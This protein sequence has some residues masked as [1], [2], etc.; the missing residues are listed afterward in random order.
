M[1]YDSISE[2]PQSEE[3]TMLS[4]GKELSKRSNFTYI[5]FDLNDNEPKLKY[6][7]SMRWK[8]AKLKYIFFLLKF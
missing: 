7:S 8:M 5:S 4:P 3:Q 2:S 6:H 1:E